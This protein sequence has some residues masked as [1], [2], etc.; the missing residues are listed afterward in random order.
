MVSTIAGSDLGYADGDG[1]HAKFNQLNGIT[2]DAQGNIYVSDGINY[3]IRK[4]TAE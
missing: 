3:R 4:I 1:L 2:A